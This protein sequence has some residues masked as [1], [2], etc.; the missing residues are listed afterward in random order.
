[1][2]PRAPQGLLALVEQLALRVNWG[3]LVLPVPRGLLALKETLV[4]VVLGR[5]VIFLSLVT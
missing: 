2:E 1:M 4:S 5:V 3:K